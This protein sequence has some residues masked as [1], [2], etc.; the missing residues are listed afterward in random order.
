M[1]IERPTISVCTRCR[2][3]DWSETANRERPGALLAC[4]L[5]QSLTDADVPPPINL[6]RVRCMSQCLR[7]CVIAFSHR[8]RF[9][10]LFGD[11][12]PTRH[13]DDVL[14]AIRMWL[15]RS[16]GFM[17]R[18]ERPPSMRRGILGRIP[19]L[20]WAPDQSMPGA[21]S[22]PSPQPGEYRGS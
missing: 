20:D 18:K 14:L 7:P 13:V 11:L 2:P 8:D 5:Q 1:T 17:A 12:D 15:S 21:R 19:P 9:T 16:D 6:R 4:A 10:Y 3:R 22:V